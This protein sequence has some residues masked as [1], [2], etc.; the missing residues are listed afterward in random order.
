MIRGLHEQITPYIVSRN[1]QCRDRAG[2]GCMGRGY[3]VVNIRNQLSE[4]TRPGEIRKLFT[5]LCDRGAAVFSI[6]VMWP[7]LVRGRGCDFRVEASVTRGGRSPVRFITV[8]RVRRGRDPGPR[9]S[10]P[11]GG[12]MERLRLS[13]LESGRASCTS[14]DMGEGRGNVAGE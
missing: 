6:S 4:R 10:T 9:A 5:V 12:G 1:H 13:P 2:T 7:S 8:R 14:R 11:F 3:A